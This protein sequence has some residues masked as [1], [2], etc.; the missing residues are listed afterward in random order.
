MKE[1]ATGRIPADYV[2]T[3]MEIHS[4][5]LNGL[6]ASWLHAEL[7]ASETKR[8]RLSAIVANSFPS[9]EAWMTSRELVYITVHC[10][11]GQEHAIIQVL[12]EYA[13][14]V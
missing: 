1:S 10:K 11:G 8:L 13:R 6:P 3:T 4:S 12:V 14:P 9:I 2:E 7:G 5:F